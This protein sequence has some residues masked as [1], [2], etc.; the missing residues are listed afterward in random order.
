[1][2]TFKVELEERLIAFAAMTR[3][4]FDGLP[5]SIK[6]CNLGFQIA[7]GASAPAFTY[8]EA[9][10]ADTSKEF[11]SKLKLCLSD[12]RQLHIS[13]RITKQLSEVDATSV[14][15]VIEECG[16]LVALFTKS[17]KTK[18]T[19]IANGKKEEAEVV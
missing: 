3:R 14:D 11:L 19:N 18:K 12:L 10:S 1:M 16:Q 6:G 5:E 13:M 9:Q 7:C 15:P 2:S 4:M 17:V 8:A